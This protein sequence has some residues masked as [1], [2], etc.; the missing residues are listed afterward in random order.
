M[1]ADL[2]PGLARVIHALL[3][4]RSVSLKSAADFRRVVAEI[5]A[6]HQIRTGPAKC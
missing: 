5:R 4:T 6:W 2:C 3:Q 1:V